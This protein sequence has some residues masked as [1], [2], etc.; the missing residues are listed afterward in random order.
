MPRLCACQCPARVGASR[1][2]AGHSYPGP[3][4]GQVRFEKAVLVRE[5]ESG[6]ARSPLSGRTSPGA[7]PSRQGPEFFC[8]SR[9]GAASGPNGPLAPPGGPCQKRLVRRPATSKSGLHEQVQGGA[10]DPLFF[11]SL[12]VRWRPSRKAG[13]RGPA[14]PIPAR[15]PRVAW[16]SYTSC[17]SP[18]KRGLVASP[19]LPLPAS[20]FRR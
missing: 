2:I 15:T 14:R 4:S 8:A 6:G 20:A 12:I 3:E 10:T 16:L 19:L 13:A 7:H 1:R 18:R 11:I 17:D 5:P 9:L